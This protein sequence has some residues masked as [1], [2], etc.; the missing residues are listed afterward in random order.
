MAMVNLFRQNWLKKAIMN[1]PGKSLKYVH[2]T[3][4]LRPQLMEPMEA[5]VMQNRVM[6][7]HVMRRGVTMDLVAQKPTIVL[8]IMWCWITIMTTITYIRILW[9]FTINMSCIPVKAT[10]AVAANIMMTADM[11]VSMAVVMIADMIADTTADTNVG[12]TVDTT[13]VMT[14]DTTVDTNVDMIV[15]TT[16]VMIMGTR[17]YTSA[18]TIVDMT[19]AVAATIVKGTLVQQEVDSVQSNPVL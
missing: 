5:A 3:A 1:S 14:V 9:S 2:W 10:H 8:V 13:A 18:D 16:V 17:V 15:D 7:G 11:T 4:T 12:M 6:L 19:A